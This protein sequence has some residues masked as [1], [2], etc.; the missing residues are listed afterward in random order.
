M[1][2]IRR[3]LV[4][5]AVFWVARWAVLEIAVHLH[6][7]RPLQSAKDSARAPGWMPLRGE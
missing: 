4:L 1:G 2:L 5:A 3:V 7:R 6:K